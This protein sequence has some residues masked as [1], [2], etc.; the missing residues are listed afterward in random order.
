MAAVAGCVDAVGFLMLTQ[1]F[2]AHMSG[3]SVAFGV[4]I[5]QGHWADAA[6]RGFPIP[7]FVM[8]VVAGGVLIEFGTR[9]GGRHTMSAVLLAEALLLCAFIVGD[10]LVRGN[11]L[12]EPGA[13]VSYYSLAAALTLSM[14]LQTAA[15]QRVSGP[16][17]RTTYITGMLTRLG[18]ESL[19]FALWFRDERRRHGRRRMAE[20]AGMV[21]RQRPFNRAALLAA[22][23]GGYVGGAVGG[24]LLETRVRA[25]ALVPA[26]VILAGI[27][28]LDHHHPLHGRPDARAAIGA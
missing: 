25:I 27:I 3:N 15:L 21:R 14:G 4:D 18:Q 26:V 1:L 22:I 13:G 2:T 20:W 5:G 9:R 23:L 10:R 6:R 24:T 16:V 12:L 28:G 8:G 19:V 11:G 17:V 7:L